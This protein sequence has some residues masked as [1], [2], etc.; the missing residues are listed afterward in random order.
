MQPQK[1]KGVTT[2]VGK[3]LGSDTVHAVSIF[4]VAVFSV[5]GFIETLDFGGSDRCG[6]RV[7]SMC[8]I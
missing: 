1:T 2:S 7:P 8:I 5:N 3:D 6:I 4:G